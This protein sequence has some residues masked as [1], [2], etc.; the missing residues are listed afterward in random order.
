MLD[1]DH[2]VRRAGGV[3][4]VSVVVASAAPTPRAVTVDPAVEDVRPPRREGVPEAG[5]TD[6]R[7]EGSVPAGG[8]LGVGFATGASPPDPPAEVAD[9]G[10]ADGDASPGLGDTTASTDPADAVVRAL[11]DPRPPR[12]A[13][14]DAAGT[15]SPDGRVP[16]QPTGDEDVTPAADPPSGELPAPVADWFA[17][18]AARADAAAALADAEGVADAGPALE[19]AAAATAGAAVDPAAFAERVAADERALRAVADR[20]AA[21]ADRCGAAEVPAAALARLA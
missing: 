21:L 14:P 9:R 12:E 8:T 1:V 5:W 6:G 2:T 11:G 7:F 16:G 18:V 15:R 17:A 20:A 19:A 10:R 4:L 3:A 13:V